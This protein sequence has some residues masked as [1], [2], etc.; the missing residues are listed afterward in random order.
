MQFE[1]GSPTARTTESLPSSHIRFSS[2]G[3]TPDNCS[4]CIACFR[5]MNP[6]YNFSSSSMTSDSSKGQTEFP[7]SL[8]HINS[9]TSRVHETRIYVRCSYVTRKRKKKKKQNT[10][11]PSN[12]Q[13]SCSWITSF[14][15][16]GC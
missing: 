9:K 8:L 12:I 15:E 11:Y 5:H 2:P 10:I 14:S 4:S 3:F 6:P 1:M 7:Y 13:F 16:R